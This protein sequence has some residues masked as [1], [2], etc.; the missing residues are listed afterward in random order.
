M[1]DVNER[2]V[3]EPNKIS[4]LL[5]IQ[6]SN[7]ASKPTVGD[8][9]MTMGSKL[10]ANFVGFSKLNTLSS[11]KRKSVCNPQQPTLEARLCRHLQ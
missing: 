11:R 7:K 8:R 2:K 3:F 6:D 5:P 9:K 4:S 10:S 1:N